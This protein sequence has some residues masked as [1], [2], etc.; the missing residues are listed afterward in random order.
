MKRRLLTMFLCL[1]LVLP[2]VF[3]A[4]CK[5]D[6]ESTPP[7]QV[8]VDAGG[9]LDNLPDADFGLRDFVMLSNPGW[10]ATEGEYN[11]DTIHDTNF[12]R[13]TYLNQR[14][15]MNFTFHHSEETFS[16]LQNTQLGG[17]QS[18]DIMYPHPND[19]GALMIG[20]Y[21]TDLRSLNMI[22]FDAEWHNASQVAN[23]TANGKTYLLAS[24]TT[25]DSQALGAIVYNRDRYSALNFT[26][27]LYQ[28]V[29]D[30]NWTMEK[31]QGIIKTAT[32]DSV[33]DDTDNSYALCFWDQ[34]ADRFA[35]A[36]GMDILRKTENGTF[37]TG[38][39]AAK[40]TDICNKIYDLIF[41]NDGI[42]HGHAFNAT[43]PTTEFFSAYKSGNSLFLTHDIGS[44][45]SLLREFDFDI[46]FLPYPKL[47]TN[48]TSYR[49]FC[50]SGMLAIPLHAQSTND[51]GIIMEALAV[52]SNLY[53]KPAFIDTI[54]LGRLSENSEDFEMLSYLHSIKYYDLGYA[55]DTDRVAN[56]IVYVQVIRNKSRE[57]VPALRSNAGKIQNIADKANTLT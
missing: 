15:N 7:P 34:F 21:L 29:W 40:M 51:S 17:D 14:Y 32:S 19:L 12:E 11:G 23:Y 35:C 20:G 54:L 16:L 4:G 50:A 53:L 8:N 9:P 49:S 25:I 28:T 18:Y 1:L 47:D 55:M 13:Y 27:D 22:D 44:L 2:T 46:G 10:M 26:E 6:E 5:K 52:Y 56:E 3:L 48:Q 37:E 39:E 43:L 33:G 41:D 38:M 30:G 42:I 57:I 31:F 36:M 24:D 45:Y